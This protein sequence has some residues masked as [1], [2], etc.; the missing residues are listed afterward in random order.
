MHRTD[1]VRIGARP[2]HRASVAPFFAF[3]LSL[4]AEA[5]DARLIGADGA[6]EVNLAK[7]R[8]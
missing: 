4:A 2:E 8:P 7:C 5:A 3:S 1:L 6:E